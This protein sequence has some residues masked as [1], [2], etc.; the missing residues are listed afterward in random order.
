MQ[1][2]AAGAR[3]RAERQAFDAQ[4]R[5]RVAS[6]LFAGLDAGSSGACDLRRNCVRPRRD[7]PAP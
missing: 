7:G 5:G 6:K 3:P 2:D 1:R 4:S